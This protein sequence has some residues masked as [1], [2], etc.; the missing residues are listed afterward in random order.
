MSEFVDTNILVYGHDRSAGKKHDRAVDLL[1][2]L[3][4]DGQ[5]ALSTQVLIEFYATAT[6][7]LKRSSEEIEAA[8][9]DL[10]DWELHRPSLEDLIRAI[11]LQRRHRISWW[12]APIVS[13]ALQLGC[14]VL[15]TEDLSH[16]HKYGSLTVR[17][18]FA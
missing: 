11:H 18:P 9:A 17:N 3:A 5:G 12:D 14:T 4:A 8:V 7:K 15:W 2:R 16:G 6:Q 1:I 10:V 13:S